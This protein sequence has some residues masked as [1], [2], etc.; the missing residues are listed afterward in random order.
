MHKPRVKVELTL[1]PDEGQTPGERIHKV[2]QPVWMRSTIEL[3]DIQDITLVLQNSGL[4]VIDIKVVRSG[5]ESHDGRET[6][7]PSLSVHT[8]TGKGFNHL[9]LN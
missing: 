6:G 4:V 5:K 1:F 7:G 9:L 2:G 8:V 3:S